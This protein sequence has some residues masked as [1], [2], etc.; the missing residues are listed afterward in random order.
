MK[1]CHSSKGLKKG[2]HDLYR[3]DW[4]DSLYVGLDQL[5]WRNLQLARSAAARLHSP[6][7]TGLQSISGLILKLHCL[8]LT[9][10]WP[11]RCERVS[12]Y[13]LYSAFQLLCPDGSLCCF[14]T[15]WIWWGVFWAGLRFNVAWWF[16]E[17]ATSSLCLLG[18]GSCRIQNSS[19]GTWQRLLF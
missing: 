16:S 9:L 17:A 7:Y 4:C 1:P 14:P 6:P 11:C 15:N 2:K 10:K 8:F 13:Q 12:M 18:C 19:S 5:S 3:P